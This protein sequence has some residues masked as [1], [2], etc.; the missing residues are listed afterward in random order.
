[1]KELEVFKCFVFKLYVGLILYQKIYKVYSS[2]LIME[3]TTIR[4]FLDVKNKL[5]EIKI[6]KRETYN[7][8]LIKLIN[9]YTKQNG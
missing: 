5:D 6:I 8:V 4:I 2:R 3:T 9:N 1:M 7:E